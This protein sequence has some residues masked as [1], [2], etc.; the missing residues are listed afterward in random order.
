[1]SVPEIILYTLAVFG[2]IW[3][4]GKVVRYIIYPLLEQFRVVK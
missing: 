4:S 3:I 1:M 2:C